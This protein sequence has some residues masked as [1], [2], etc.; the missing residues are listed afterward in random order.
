MPENRLLD[1]TKA[2]FLPTRKRVLFSFLVGAVAVA[3]INIPIVSIPIIFAT[4]PLF[5]LFPVF[6]QTGPHVEWWFLGLY[7]TS[8]TAYISFFIYYYAIAYLLMFGY[9]YQRIKQRR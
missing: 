9:G 8:I 1:F 6:A 5:K 7:L 2:L 3:G 4:Y